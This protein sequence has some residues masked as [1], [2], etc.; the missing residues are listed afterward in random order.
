MLVWW[1][2]TNNITF[3]V[4]ITVI[5]FIVCQQARTFIS[6]D[7]SSRW[8]KS[9]TFFITSESAKQRTVFS[10]LIISRLAIPPP[11]VCLTPIPIL[12]KLSDC[13]PSQLRSGKP[14]NFYISRLKVGGPI[15]SLFCFVFL[16][17]LEFDLSSRVQSITCNH[18]VYIW[19][20]FR[21]GQ[22][23]KSTK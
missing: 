19:K 4:S 1:P 13:V 21:L 18:L 2:F 15:A 12:S 17:R 3:H 11:I 14:I 8:E 22:I 20:G 9:R 16:L 6:A 7:K 5:E 10:M 23:L